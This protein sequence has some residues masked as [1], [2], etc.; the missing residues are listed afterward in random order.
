MCIDLSFL[1][2][3]FSLF[4]SDISLACLTQNLSK[5]VSICTYNTYRQST[6]RCIFGITTSHDLSPSLLLCTSSLTR[7]TSLPSISIREP[8]S[9]TSLR[10]APWMPL[11]NASSLPGMKKVGYHSTS[12]MESSNI[13]LQSAGISSFATWNGF[14]ETT[15]IKMV[16]DSYIGNWKLRLE[17][18]TDIL[19]LV[20]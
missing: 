19:R 20:F 3:F 16:F 12:V 11:A 10:E 8:L 13:K 7:K 2:S 17:M 6:A 9:R 4:T 5:A 15:N 14:L 18:R 1:G